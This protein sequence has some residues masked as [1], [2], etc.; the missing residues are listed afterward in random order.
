MLV[1]LP[2]D[3]SLLPKEEAKQQ[4]G[5][6]CYFEMFMDRPDPVIPGITILEATNLG[7]Q[8]IGKPFRLQR[9]SPSPPPQQQSFIQ[10]GPS[11]LFAQISPPLQAAPSAMAASVSWPEPSYPQPPYFAAH[12]SIPSSSAFVMEGNPSGSFHLPSSSN[13]FAM[14]PSSAPS[15]LPSSSAFAIE[16]T[17]SGP[18]EAEDFPA[19]GDE[20]DLINFDG[21]SGDRIP[22]EQSPVVAVAAQISGEAP[23]DEDSQM[24]LV[25]Q[26]VRDGENDQNDQNFNEHGLNDHHFDDQFFEGQ[27][28]DNQDMEDQDSEYGFG[29]AM[30]GSMGQ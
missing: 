10:P 23:V 30:G 7:L 26:F 14:E 15:R 21:D 4:K 9:R 8:E 20:W 19:L 2:P 12:P 22:D 18:P 3:H 27:N 17:P 11:Q 5:R 24:A 1:N 28:F 13:A 29:I 6:R 16:E 25:E